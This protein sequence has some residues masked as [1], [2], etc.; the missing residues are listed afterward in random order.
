[1]KSKF[2]INNA[3]DV[4]LCL[5]DNHTLV[6]HKADEGIVL[7]VWNNQDDASVWSTYHFTSEMLPEENDDE[8]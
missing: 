2:R 1:M 8:G 5:D 4:E 6:I 7:D 3:G